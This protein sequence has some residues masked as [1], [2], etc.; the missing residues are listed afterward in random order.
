M[1]DSIL[2]NVSKRSQIRGAIDLNLHLQ[3][4]TSRINE[5]ITEIKSFLA[6]IPEVQSHTVLLN[7]IRLQAY[8]VFVEF[9]TPPIAWPEFTAIKER[10]NFHILQTMDRLQIKIATEGKDLAIVP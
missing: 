4:P 10:V 1:V 8:V 9:Y 2:D 3:T 7:D 6:S 5:L